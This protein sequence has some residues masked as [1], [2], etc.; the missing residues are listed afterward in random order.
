MERAFTGAVARLHALGLVHRNLN[1]SNVLV[2]T[3]GTPKLIGFGGVGIQTAS[4]QLPPGAPGVSH[5]IDVK[6]LQAM[7]AWLFSA[8]GQPIPGSL[9]YACRSA[10]SAAAFAALVTQ[11]L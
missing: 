4:D 1:P 11:G 5:A 2:A 10:S 3:D 6:S 7:L 8:L 9:E